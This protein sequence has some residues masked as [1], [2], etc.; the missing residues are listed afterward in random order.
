MDECKPLVAGIIGQPFHGYKLLNAGGAGSGEVPED[1]HEWESMGR[2]VWGGRGLGVRGLG[3]IQYTA[4]EPRVDQI[5][6]QPPVVC[7]N[8]ITRDD[9]IKF[10]MEALSAEVGWCNL[11]TVSKLAVRQ[12]DRL[13]ASCPVSVLALFH[14]SKL[15]FDC[16][17]NC[18][19]VMLQSP[20]CA[21]PPRWGSRCPPRGSTF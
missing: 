10:V 3:E 4:D 17:M 15:M 14:R 20:T 13:L 7:I 6:S 19:K 5:A 9:R 18:F 1:P 8:R 11:K 2:T 16:M 12:H 21:P